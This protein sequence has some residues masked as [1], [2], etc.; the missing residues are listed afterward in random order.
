MIGYRGVLNEPHVR[1][2]ARLALRARGFS[3][4][5]A[6]HQAALEEQWRLG[7]R[8]RDEVLRER[9]PRSLLD[10]VWEQIA[11]VE[12]RLWERIP[13]L[14]A[15][16]HRQTR[17]LSRLLDPA[18]A[19]DDAA[20]LGGAFNA[21]IAVLDYLLDE[22]GL[23]A[24]LFGLLRPELVAAIFKR[25]GDWESYLADVYAEMTD[26]RLRFF[27]SLFAL[28]GAG[29]R[30][31]HRRSGND[32]VWMEL[33]LSIGRLLIAERN[34]S[35]AV[36]VASSGVA[37]SLADVEAKSALPSVAMLYIAALASPPPAAPGP[38]EQAAARALGQIFWRVDEL[39]DL[40][41]D[42]RR[43]EPS[44]LVQRLGAQVPPS[45]EGVASD[46]DLYDIIEL[47]G[48]ELV[49]AL[50]PS[51]FGAAPGSS[52]AAISD[53]VE[54][55]RMMVAAW[56]QL[57]EDPVE[58]D[59]VPPV[60]Q[61]ARRQPL[62]R[63]TE[64]MLA[65]QRDAFREAVHHLRFPRM[66]WVYETHPAWV[67]FRAVALDALLDAHRAG[68]GVPPA[69]LAAEAMALL[70]GKHRL[71]RGGWNYTPDVPELPPDTDDLGQIAQVLHRLG[72]R[73]L[74]LTCDEGIW[75]A[76]NSAEPDGGIHTWIL[77]PRV[78]SS[79]DA[80]V[81]QYLG[82]MGGW[83]VHP[84]V[85]ANFLYGLLLVDRDR[86]AQALQQG[87][88]Y[89]RSVQAPEGFWPCKW[90][91]GPYY[92]TFR[93]VAVLASL[94]PGSEALDRARSFLVSRQLPSGAFGDGEGEPLS[95][96]LACLAL[97]Q[98]GEHRAAA[99]AEQYLIGTQEPDGGFAACTWISFPSM[100][101][102]VDYGS[103]T[104]TTAF[105]LK[106][107]VALHDRLRM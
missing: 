40:V 72:G 5:R 106:A 6:A 99:R 16:G 78:S 80:I 90:Y 88:D 1:A 79:A 30:A 22:R 85:V 89:L 15:L 53:V 107:M 3:V 95:T 44:S 58:S 86:Y 68:L 56:V 12:P 51:A 67:S 42:C 103:R 92:G 47:A 33:G 38:R 20:V 76:L 26:P 48:G 83:G 8:L 97:A 61:G 23:H 25:S 37:F 35:S 57:Q 74:S 11:Q 19:Q 54:F 24:E 69:V 34:V 70:R 66:G 36:H 64:M 105:C 55:A 27:F 82:I 10:P 7:H 32:A 59:A 102:P 93:V 29:G 91:R 41:G 60:P 49:A 39:V 18:A 96:A 104:M 2:A 77:D 94:A 75:L 62:E 84:E 13:L 101:G 87:S 28:C 100:D 65:Q 63:A 43:G 81:R 21:A 9:I 4:P 52:D 98:L 71:V 17:V 45:R 73:A 14:F 31:L 50:D 46:A